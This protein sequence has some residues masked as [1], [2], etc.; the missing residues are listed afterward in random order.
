MERKMK[1]HEREKSLPREIYYSDS[2]FSYSQLWSFVEQIHH[3]RQLRTQS[4]I[5]IGVG[6]GFVSTF[7]RRM[8]V[9]VKTFDINPNLT[10]DV[11]ASLHD[12]GNFV[13]PNEF[14]LISCCEVLEHMPFDEFESAIR[15]FSSLSDRL[16]LTL[17]VHGMH[18]GLGGVI[19]FPRFHRWVGAWLRLPFKSRQLPEMHFWEIDYD[20][21]M[22]K[23]EIFN[24]LSKYYWK[25]ET[26]CFKA[27]PYHRYFRCAVSKEI[28]R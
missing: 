21:K 18:I 19:K 2:Y 23:K 10:P 5:E 3:I 13:K 20:H 16:F 6:N 12:I 25:V 28:I 27:N 22:S 8:G 1:G 24:L 14:D 4:L 11:V 15:K 7:L 17:P 9:N 26:G